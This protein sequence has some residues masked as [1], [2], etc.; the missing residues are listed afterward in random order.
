MVRNGQIE[1]VVLLAK[2]DLVSPEELERLIGQIRQMGTEAKIICVNNVTGV[3][4]DQ[5]RECMVPGKTYGLLGSSGVG[6]TSLINR[7][8]GGGALET[9]EVSHSGKG[10]HTTTRRQLI[11]LEQ[12][13]L[14]ID[15]PGTRV[16]NAWRR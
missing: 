15:M 8:L 16:G 14:L 6:K 7:L 5:V 12:G 2:T 9:G 3:G 4:V 13:G 10:R 11:V 1:P